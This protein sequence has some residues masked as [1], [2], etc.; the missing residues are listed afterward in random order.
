MDKFKKLR[1]S[2]IKQEIERAGEYGYD[3]P[4]YIPLTENFRVEGLTAI[5]FSQNP[6][7]FEELKTHSQKSYANGALFGGH[8]QM[9]KVE[10]KGLICSIEADCA[11]Y[12]E[13]LNAVE[14]RPRILRHF[15]QLAQ[16]VDDQKE[17]EVIHRLVLETVFGNDFF[18]KGGGADDQLRK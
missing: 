5:P 17:I 9:P 15:H 16:Q 14:L 12:K 7:Q 8:P 3:K 6:H 18:E 1:L 10:P 13:D 11:A 4:S 2:K